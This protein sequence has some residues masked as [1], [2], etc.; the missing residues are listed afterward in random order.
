MKKNLVVILVDQWRNKTIGYNDP[1]VLTPH[2]D[3]FYQDSVSFQNAVTVCPLCSPCRSALFTGKYPVQNGVYGNCMTGYDIALREDEECLTDVL[4]RN[5]Y[6]TAYIGKWHLD[7]PELNHCDAP[8]SGASGWDAYTP[9]GKRRHHIDYWH[10]YN[11]WNEHMHQH[12]WE[13]SP[14]KIQADSWSPI[15][16]TDRAIQFVEQNSGGPFAL[17]LAWNPPHTPFEQVPQ[18]YLDLYQNK[19][20]RM[21][22]VDTDVYTNHTGEPGF[23]GLD[24]MQEKTRQYYA[25]VSGLDDQFGRLTACL[26]EKGLYDDTLILVTADHGEHLGSHGLVGK[27]TWYEE[28]VN[29]PMLLRFPPKLKPHKNESCVSTV[30]L[31]PTL[32]SLLDIQ[33]PAWQSRQ[34]A[35]K[36]LEAGRI[37]A[38]DHSFIAGYIS[39]DVF[40]EAFR[41]IGVPPVDVGWRAV[42]D[43]RWTYVIVRGYMPEQESQILLYDRWLDPQQ[44]R[45]ADLKAAPWP[46][47]AKALHV[48]LMRHLKTENPG[49]ARWVEQE[50]QPR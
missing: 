19:T 48:L 34:D 32:L 28:S 16:E 31:M 6:R 45:P 36:D 41:A 40:I 50:L 47:Q 39:R 44:K 33:P 49:F 21:D 17:F 25:C 18:K 15:H 1:Q 12:Y 29:V 26:R 22:N 27:H 43:P 42:R 37:V 8:E 2:F 7:E 46:P 23:A 3:A 10:A 5:G 30:Q 38:E 13:D 20:L 35:S 14:Q 11:A 4:S 9:P 24:Q